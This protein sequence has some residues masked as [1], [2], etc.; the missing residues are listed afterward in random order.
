MVMMNSQFQ[1][2]WP[3]AV[4]A[5]L[6][7]LLLTP[8][9]RAAAVRLGVVDA[10]GELKIHTTAIPRLG[11]VAMACGFAVATVIAPPASRP[12]NAILLVL[13][14]TWLLGV[15]D[16]IRSLPALLRLA[17]QLG[18]GALLWG[19]H[20]GVQISGNGL[21]NLVF[22]ALFF[23]FTVNAWNLLDGMDGLALSVSAVVALAFASVFYGAY[24][25]GFLLALSVFSVSAA[26]LFYNKPPASIFIGDS[27]STLLGAV[28]AVLSLDW[29][30]ELPAPRSFLVPLLF[31]AI[32][33]GDALAAMI[34]RVRMGKSPFSG[35][36]SHFYDLLR[37][38]N[39]TASVI[40]GVSVVA[41]AAFAFLGIIAA[42][43][44]VDP[45]W[46]AVAAAIVMCILG[47]FMGSFA[48]ERI[49]PGPLE[50]R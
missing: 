48:R 5:F 36:R 4:A 32:P 20:A 49:S 50:D 27:G 43:G 22:T 35:D 3:L 6:T 39:W 10:P 33:L 7:T 9:V 44:F 18:A 11:G 1:S 31:V 23:S 17:V 30:H 42:R 21:V 38:Q 29:V 16:D 45:R 15:C 12:A 28:F 13:G 37:G 41:T 40:L 47:F 46:T 24:P 14:I 19:A 34:R 26:A 25:A 8:V 2:L